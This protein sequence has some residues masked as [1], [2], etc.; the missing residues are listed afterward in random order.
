MT[1]DKGWI[2][3]YRKFTD[4]EWYDDANVMRLFIHLLLCA[5]HKDSKWRGV[6]IRRGQLI[7]SQPKLANSLKLSI[8]QIR[9]S[10]TKLKSTGEITVKSTSEYSIISI[11]NYDMYQENNRRDNAQT[12]PEQQSGNRQATT[13]NN[14]NNISSINSTSINKSLSAKNE[15]PKITKEE[16]EILKSYSKKEGAKNINAYVRKLIDTGDYLNILEEEKEKA[17]KKRAE[18][19]RFLIEKEKQEQE[20]ELT[21]EERQAALEKA[22]ELAG[23]NKKRRKQNG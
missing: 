3:L 4:W 8:M 13:N 1:E 12:S 6:L 23:I 10:L 19:A 15:K 2:S 9:N 14:D 7:T 18:R 5:N 17:E 16:R 22:R 11:K 21:Q 20:P